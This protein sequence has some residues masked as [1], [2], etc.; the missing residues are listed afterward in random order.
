MPPCLS[1]QACHLPAVMAVTS[2]SPGTGVGVNRSVVLPSPNCPLELLP[3][4]ETVPPC[5]SAQE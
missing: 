1:A 3:Q 5:L 4:Q 2:V